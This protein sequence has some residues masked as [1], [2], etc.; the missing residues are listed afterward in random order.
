MEKTRPMTVSCVIPT[1]NRLSYLRRAID[2]V[3]AQTVP[4]DE[5]VVID[6]G[7]TDGT[8]D[9]LKAEY[10][11]LLRVV[12]QANTGVSGA[13]RRGVQEA[14][15][16]WIAFLDSDDVWTTNH[17]KDLLEGASRVSEDV[18]WIFGDL[19]VVREGGNEGTLFELFGLSVK[20]CPQ[21]FAD[22][23]SIVNVLKTPAFLLQGSMI[24]RSVLRELDCFGEGLRCGED[25]LASHQ[26]ACRYRFAAI[27]SVVGSCYRT[28]DLSKSSASLNGFRTPDHFRSR[29]M[30]IALVI[31]SGRR[32]PW[33]KLYASEVRLL[34]RAL[35][36]RGQP[37][38]R[39]LA[40]QQFRFGIVSA[41][42]IAFFCVAMLGHR[43]IQVW[44]RM[45]ESRTKYLT[46]EAVDL[47]MTNRVTAC[48]PPEDRKSSPKVGKSLL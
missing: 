1:F 43:G 5:V 15:G 26:V 39:S 13:R 18:A 16:E 34:C 8:A 4:V 31:K 20:E 48:V 17:N 40:L 33:N 25:T 42:G 21:I 38:P 12:R 2:S 22:S 7:S 30:S 46:A 9:A 19:W 11:T 14:R 36:H 37:V 44:N 6:D 41:K 29:M 32:R 45:V 23:F 27:R 3:S 47:V 28:F 10:G 24:R 35:A